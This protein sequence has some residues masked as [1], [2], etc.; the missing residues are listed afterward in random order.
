MR[1]MFWTSLVL[2]LWWSHRHF[3]PIGSGRTL[4]SYNQ[5]YSLVLNIHIYIYIC[6]GGID[7]PTT[8]TL[9]ESNVGNVK[10]ID[11]NGV[12]GFF[13]HQVD[14]MISAAKCTLLSPGKWMG[15]LKSQQPAING[16]DPKFQ[17]TKPWFHI[18]FT[19]LSWVFLW[20]GPF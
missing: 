9:C 2:H 11:L 7:Q 10:K 6:I 4:Q 8:R 1:N 3:K 15:F 19:T 16:W 17:A 14:R 13:Y 20:R 18:G 12:W 5:V